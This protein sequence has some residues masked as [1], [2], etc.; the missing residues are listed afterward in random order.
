[1]TATPPNPSPSQSPTPSARERI[2]DATMSCV[3]DSGLRGW[4]LDDVAT[5]AGVARATIYRQFPGGRDELIR[6]AVTREVATFWGEI[7]DAVRGLPHLEDRLVV[8]IMAAHR[9]IANYELLQRL[10]ASEPGDLLTMLFES[11]EL[12]HTLMVGYLE[13]LLGREPLREGI[14]AAEAAEYLARMLVGY[15]SANGQ[16]D[17]DDEERVR[18]LVRT[19]FLA[20]ILG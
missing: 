14:D 6:A 8:G 4:A 7:A 1:M 20:G 17:L 5:A 16:W 9:R 13:R 2:L 10:L 12:V 3:E 18:R 15:V 11:D 19:Q